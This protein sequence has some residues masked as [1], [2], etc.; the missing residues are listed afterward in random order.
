[1]NFT[2]RQASWPAD[3]AALKAVRTKVFVAEQRVP[4]PLEWDGLDA[5]AVHALAFDTND[6]PV[7]TGRLLTTGQI[8]RMAVLERMRGAGVG[9]AL[10]QALIDEARAQGLPECFLHAQT[11]ALGFYARYGFCAEDEEFDEAGIPHRTMRLV[12]PRA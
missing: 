10:L 11:H 7:G 2:I 5:A 3:L 9:G 1:M 8:G 12:F 6:K 4:E